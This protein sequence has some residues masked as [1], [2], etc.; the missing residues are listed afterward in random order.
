MVRCSECG[1]EIEENSA[2][3]TEIN[4]KEHYFHTHHVWYIS[5][6]KDSKNGIVQK[7]FTIPRRL[8]LVTIFNKTLAEVLAI[9]AGLGG[10]VYTIKDLTLRALFLDT[11]SFIAAVSALLMGIEHISFL[12]RRFLLRRIMIVVG[13]GVTL[14]VALTVWHFITG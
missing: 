14:G 6:K 4:G 5:V 11:I 13:I 1:A 12:R 9:G 7:L 8:L 10:I 3:K 2:V